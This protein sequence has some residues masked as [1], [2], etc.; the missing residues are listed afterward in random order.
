MIQDIIKDIRKQCRLAMNG[1]TSTSMRQKG[2]SYKINFGLSFQQIKDLAQRYEPNAELAETIWR[3]DTRELKILATLLYPLPEFT[4]E[5]AD[6]WVSE[7]PNQEIRERICFN[8]FQNLLFANELVS[9]WGDDDKE[10]I[11]TTGYWLLARLSVQKLLGSV[12][13]DDFR[14]LLVDVATDNISLRN[15]ATLAL[16]HIGRQSKD[17]ADAILKKLSIEIKDDL[18]EQEVYDSLDFEFS[19]YFDN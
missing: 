8:L 1:V 10:E 3:E 2:L 6:R 19:Y 7:I 5:V 4:K 16:K 9:L 12:K 15:A 13:S 14:Y 18:I 17:E 11:R